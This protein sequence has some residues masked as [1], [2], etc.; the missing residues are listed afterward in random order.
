MQSQHRIFSPE[1]KYNYSR[2][3]SNPWRDSGR[4]GNHCLHRRAPVDAGILDPNYFFLQKMFRCLYL[5]LSQIYFSLV[6][7]CVFWKSDLVGHWS[8]VVWS[9]LYL[10]LLTL[11]CLE[12]WMVTGAAGATEACRWHHTILS[13]SM[14]AGSSSRQSISPFHTLVFAF[15]MTD[16][17]IKYLTPL[18]VGWRAEREKRE[19][20][21]LG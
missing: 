1:K 2:L 17:L 15:V 7:S 21:W 16:L 13:S 12:A 20:R 6:F 5:S 10:L 11:F 8:L 19:W 4:L 3:V 14:L 9:I 18:L